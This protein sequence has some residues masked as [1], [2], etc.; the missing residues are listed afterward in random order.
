M[1]AQWSSS[2]LWTEGR[3][4]KS[5]GWRDFPIFCSKNNFKYLSFLV[6]PNFRISVPGV[7]NFNLLAK[8]EGGR[9]N[10][11]L[12]C[13]I[14]TACELQKGSLRTKSIQKWDFGPFCPLSEAH[15]R[16]S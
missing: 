9:S 8:V 7:Q 13:S 6:M 1:V 16:N 5:S 3:E 11:T 15:S 14:S 10:A 12:Q 4:F 2:E